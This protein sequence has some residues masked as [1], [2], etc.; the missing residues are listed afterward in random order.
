MFCHGSSAPVYIVGTVSRVLDSLPVGERIGIAFSGGLDT[1]VAVAW[2]REHGAIPYA[3][4]GRSRP[5][6]R[7][8]PRRQSAAERTSTAPR[9]RASSTAAPSSSTRG[10][11]RC[12]AARSTSR[13]AGKTYFNTTPLGRAV[14]GTLLVHA[15]RDDGVDIWGDG[16][17]LQG[18][19][20]RALLP[21]RAARQPGSAHLQAVAR[22]RSSSPSSAGAGR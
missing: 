14:T 20:H 5:V 19:R 7:A 1:S 17:H 21:L 15:M 6:R 13:R 12:S 9:R 18:Q 16:S 2:I 4:H 10:S 11:S 3:L 22:R 8:R